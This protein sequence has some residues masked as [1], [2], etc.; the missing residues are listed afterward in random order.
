LRSVSLFIFEIYDAGSAPQIDLY[1][2]VE[3]RE[4]MAEFRNFDMLGAQ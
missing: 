4:D 3:H 1:G 2:M